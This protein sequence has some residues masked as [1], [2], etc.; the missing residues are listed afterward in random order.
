MLYTFGDSFTYG[1]NFSEQ[2]RQEL[3]W[4]VVLSKQLGV[5]YNNLAAPGASNW[6]TA[7]LINML[8][9]TAD[10]IVV[11]GW[12]ES[13]RFE[14]GVSTSHSQRPNADRP[15]DVIEQLGSV[16][17]KKFFPQLLDRTNDA[18]SKELLNLAYGPFYN[19]DWYD[20]MFLI[21]FGS[22]VHRLSTIGCKWTVFN[23]WTRQY[24]G[25]TNQLD[26]PQYL[27]G[28]KNT[29]NFKLRRNAD[30]KYWNK[31]EHIAVSQIIFEHLNEHKN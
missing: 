8:D 16:R 7:R 1:F 11:V 10:D 23:T 27:L 9:I 6:R 5:P 30:L 22:V 4:P 12:S 17:T 21:M 3:V 20:E 25:T 13:T 31:E 2:E 19:T 14:F 24:H 26:I 15:A 18:K 29:M 28:H